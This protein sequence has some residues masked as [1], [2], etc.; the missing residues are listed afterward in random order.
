MKT[1]RIPR[2]MMKWKPTW[3]GG[4][5]TAVYFSDVSTPK[6]HRIPRDTYEVC[7]GIWPSLVE[8]CRRFFETF[9]L[10][11]QD[12]SLPF[13][14][15]GS[16]KHH[17]ISVKFPSSCTELH[18]K[19]RPSPLFRYQMHTCWGVGSGA[20]RSLFGSKKVDLTRRR[21]RLYAWV[22]IGFINCA[23]GVRLMGGNGV[24]QTCT[25]NWENGILIK[26]LTARSC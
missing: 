8:V 16:T 24:G 26:E 15:D 22:A 21:K 6:Q 19:R 5:G 4:G 11:I 13:A 3:G 9:Y 12:S 20:L 7:R 14:W 23:L 25:K 1:G 10:T 18:P 2:L 17:R